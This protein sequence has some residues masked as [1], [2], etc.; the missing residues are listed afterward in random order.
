MELPLQVTF[1]HMDPSP[2][3]EDKVEE[4]ARK[5][6]RVYDRVTSCRVVIEAPHKHHHKGRLYHVVVE[7]AV[8]D[9]RLVASRE[10]DQHHAHE[11]LY[12]AIRDAFDAIRRQLEG[13][14]RR[15]RGDVKTHEAPP[16]GRIMLLVAAR[17]YGLIETPD[18]REI[19]FHRNSVVDADFDTLEVGAEVR[20][21]EEEGDDGP[22]ASTV[23]ITG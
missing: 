20:F 9:G 4:H 7:L 12:V 21:I 14:A 5:L 19:Y 2:A 18:G 6:R 16:R 13:Y 8:P 1:R 22:Q 3:V 17:D 10:R 11:D 23:H 15:R